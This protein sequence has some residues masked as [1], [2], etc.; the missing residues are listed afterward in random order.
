M[1]RVERYHAKIDLA[2]RDPWKKVGTHFMELIRMEREAIIVLCPGFAQEPLKDEVLKEQPED[3]P[4]TKPEPEVK[5][6]PTEE[7]KF[8]TGEL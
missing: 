2:T 1:D 7:P 5:P 3:A 4:F 8:T 6:A